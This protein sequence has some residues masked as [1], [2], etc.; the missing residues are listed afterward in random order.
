ME[1]NISA[2]NG[3]FYIKFITQYY[4]VEQRFSTYGA[5]TTG[6]TRANI[7]WYMN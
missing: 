6:G 7:E 2:H 3:L 4:P 1:D 5:R